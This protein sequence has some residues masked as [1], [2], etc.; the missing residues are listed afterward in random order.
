MDRFRASL[1]LDDSVIISSHIVE[2]TYR[3]GSD[4]YLQVRWD[5]SR[6]RE[7]DFLAWATNLMTGYEELKYLATIGEWPLA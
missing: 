2:Y 1:E 4:L 3:S 6:K 7:I 5:M